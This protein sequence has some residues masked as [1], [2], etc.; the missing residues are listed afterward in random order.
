M[1]KLCTKW[2][3]KWAKKANLSNYDLLESI[4]NVEKGKGVEKI[5]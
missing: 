2:F 5:G 1:E 3:K 4:N